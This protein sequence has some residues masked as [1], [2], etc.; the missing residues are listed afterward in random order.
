MI[1]RPALRFDDGGE[2]GESISP[3]ST[4]LINNYRNFDEF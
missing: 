2:G 3:S 4:N 1:V